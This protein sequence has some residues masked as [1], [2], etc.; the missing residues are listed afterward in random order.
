MHRVFVVLCAC[1]GTAFA[2]VA[3]AHAAASWGPEAVMSG[4]ANPVDA[5]DVSVGAG[6]HAAV[7]WERDGNGGSDRTI[8][9][10]RRSPAGVWGGVEN[11]SSP[12]VD[13]FVPGQP[14]YSAHDEPSVAVDASGNTL[15]TWVTGGSTGPGLQGNLYM[16]A[17][18]P[19]GQPVAAQRVFASDANGS[20]GAA[21]TD[22]QFGP[23]GEALITWVEVDE[24][25]RSVVRA[26]NG[27]FGAETVL[28]K[29]APSSDVLAYD[30]SYGREGTAVLA[31]SEA[32]HVVDHY[33]KRAFTAVRR[34]GG[35]WSAPQLLAEDLDPQ[36]YGFWIEVAAADD[37]SAIAVFHTETPG[38]RLPSRVAALPRDSATF[39]APRP[40]AGIDAE[41]TPSQLVAS[42][43]GRA[44]LIG[45]VGA[46][47]KKRAAVAEV[48]A[49]GASASITAIGDTEL[50]LG[51]L[52]AHLTAAFDTSGGLHLAWTA[53][54]RARPD[55]PE[56]YYVYRALR[57][58]DGAFGS[59]TESPIG[60][61][62][63]DDLALAAGA[64]GEVVSAWSAGAKFSTRQLF[65]NTFGPAAAPIP[66]TP[67]PTPPPTVLPAA[68]P[69][70][71][72]TP[73]ASPVPTPAPG[74]TASKPAAVAS[75]VTAERSAPQALNFAFGLT[76]APQTSEAPSGPSRSGGQASSAGCT[77]PDVRGTTLAQAKRR[78]I[79]AHCRVGKVRYVKV[80]RPGRILRQN[81][82]GAV[83]AAAFPV[84]L[85]VARSGSRR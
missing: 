40:L 83:R 39:S 13:G 73:S 71:T 76:P 25:I 14:A 85:V 27:T 45:F 81:T 35:A 67:T 18:A 15:V 3:P 17:F 28:P 10:R 11:V 69:T 53:S 57:P 68:T 36:H 19:V 46:E 8:H 70:P 75:E 59:P 52:S 6:G 12:Y 32:T 41:F 20:S 2:F 84:A 74:P 9:L 5:V 72:A 62:W 47:Q 82:P 79:R 7:V 34:P 31:W 61:G 65:V 78:L 60:R 55:Q 42:E 77:I 80:G 64:G 49:D 23:S 24:Q 48:T 1:L 54:P 63:I 22:V 58:A 50:E 66:A 38:A 37:G 43:P 51:P 56:R 21:K 4:T 44:S 29:T 16:E 26:P 30:I 33:D